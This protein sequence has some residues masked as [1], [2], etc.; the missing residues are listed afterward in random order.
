MIKKFN[1]RK[2]IVK[3]MVDAGETAGS[4]D[5]EHWRWLE[6]VLE[7]LGRDGM[8]SEDSSDE[9]IGESITR[10]CRPRVMKWRRD[11]EQEL[12]I[13]DNQRTLDRDLFSNKGQR[14]TLRLRSSKNGASTR[15]AIAGLPRS[16]YDN[17]WFY[18][19]TEHYK[20]RHLKVSKEKFQWYAVATTKRW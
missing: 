14:P 7:K 8:S 5:V 9:G 10:V 20:H 1:R 4:P 15:K 19:Q 2:T 3:L 13:I 16:F 17:E 12:K 6:S 11:M 18:K